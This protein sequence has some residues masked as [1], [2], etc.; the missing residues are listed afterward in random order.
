MRTLWNTFNP[1]AASLAIAIA[2][3]IWLFVA[4]DLGPAYGSSRW[5][6]VIRVPAF[7]FGLY[8]YFAIAFNLAGSK[9][10][11]RRILGLLGWLVLGVLAPGFLANGLILLVMTLGILVPHVTHLPLNLGATQTAIHVTWIGFLVALCSI[12]VLSAI[13]IHSRK[14]TSTLPDA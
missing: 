5:W 2:L 12:G 7:A 11:R 3:G 1:L 10:S 13:S 9:L 6:T 14:A 4:I 8:I